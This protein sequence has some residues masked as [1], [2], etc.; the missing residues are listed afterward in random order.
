MD[1]ERRGVVF[2]RRFYVGISFEL[3]RMSFAR[4]ARG[5]SPG[6]FKL[7][8]G[9]YRLSRVGSLIGNWSGSIWY[10]IGALSI[11]AHFYFDK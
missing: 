11:I 6:L 8:Q 10:G 2:M 1:L 9:R 7:Y 5:L 4:G 3:L